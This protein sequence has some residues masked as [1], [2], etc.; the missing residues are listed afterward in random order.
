M[1]CTLDAERWAAQ[2]PVF[3]GSEAAWLDAFGSAFSGYKPDV[4]PTA[5]MTAGRHALDAYGP[6]LHPVVAA[7]LEAWLGP[8]RVTPAPRES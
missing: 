1:D 3:K 4:D 8:I 2:V 7:S 6:S 5:C